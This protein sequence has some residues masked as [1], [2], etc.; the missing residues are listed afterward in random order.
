MPA[1]VT[2]AAYAFWA[3]I[4]LCLG[5][6]MAVSPGRF[7][8]LQAWLSRTTKWLRPARERKPGLQFRL[9]GLGIAAVGVMLLRPV[10]YSAFG[11]WLAFSKSQ[12]AAPETN[13]YA[14][15]VGVALAAGGLYVVAEPRLVLRWTASRA[16][17]VTLSADEGGGA[18]LAARLLGALVTAIGLLAMGLWARSI[19]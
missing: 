5:L 1:S 9:A 13:W 3:A 16:H 7:L 19:F 6:L 17:H 12:A 14:L 4:L 18:V 8:E 2:N 10:F 15:G 11:G